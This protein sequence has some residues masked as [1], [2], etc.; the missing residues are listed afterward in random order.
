MP[1]QKTTVIIPT[2]NAGALIARCLDSVLCQPA[3]LTEVIVVDG[4]SRDNTLDVVKDYAARHPQL[5]WVSA[6]DQ[7]IYDAM[8]KGAALATGDWLFFLGADDAL[9]DA[10]TLTRLQ[11]HLSAELDFVYGDIFRV[12]RQRRE[13]GV[14]D[15]DRLLV[16]NICHQAVFYR[17]AFYEQVGRYKL[18]YRIYADWDFN[19]RCYAANAR[20]AYVAMLISRYDGGG[21]SSATTDT[22]FMA[23]RHA[24]IARLWGVSQWHRVLRPCR[25]AFR[26]EA[27]TALAERRHARAASLYARFAWHALMARL[28]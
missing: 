1:L 15:R 10:D 20:T 21:F 22:V 27:I 19:I 26:E 25:Y 24:E 16:Q 23:R 18:D 11:P 8:N 14:V 3:E 28:D 12:S 2:F 5:R 4:A 6:P 9:H 17:R 13:G 7:G